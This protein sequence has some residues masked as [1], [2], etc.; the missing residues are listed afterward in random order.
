MPLLLAILT[1]LFV[2]GFAAVAMSLAINPLLAVVGLSVTAGQMLGLI[3]FVAICR[4]LWN[5]FDF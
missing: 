5:L 2:L 4:A 3:I 1:V